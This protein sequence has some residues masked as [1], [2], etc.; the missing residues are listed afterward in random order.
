MTAHPHTT[1]ATLT[2]TVHP[3]ITVA[4]ITTT[5]HPNITVATITTTAHPHTPVATI[6]STNETIL[7]TI[8]CF[9]VKIEHFLCLL[10]E[11]H[12]SE[13]YG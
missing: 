5:V 4:T 12:C 10:S 11:F 9:P 2:S 6:T 8:K 1:L 13:R 3:N 7:S